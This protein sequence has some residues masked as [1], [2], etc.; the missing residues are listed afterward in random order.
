MEI[1]MYRYK[2]TSYFDM[3]GHDWTVTIEYDNVTK[4]CPATYWEPAEPPGY[5]IGRIWLSRDEYKYSGPDWELTG[6]M[7]WLVSNLDKIHNSV[8]SDINYGD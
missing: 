1:D 4:G 3:M 7:Y 8:I 2:T 6:E 5:D